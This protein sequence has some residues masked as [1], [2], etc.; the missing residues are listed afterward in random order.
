MS[1][2]ECIA[3][4]RL[5]RKLVPFIKKMTAAQLASYLRA[6]LGDDFTGVGFDEEGR[7]FQTE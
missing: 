6:A 3:L 2:E 5:M 7:P 1:R 4:G